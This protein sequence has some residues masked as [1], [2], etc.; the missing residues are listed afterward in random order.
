MDLA[1]R[2]DFLLRTQAVV[3]G[4]QKST[5]EDC[6]LV[7]IRLLDFEQL[8][9]SLGYK[10]LDELLTDISQKLRA[11]VAPGDMVS[12]WHGG[13]FSTLHSFRNKAETIHAQEIVRFVLGGLMQPFEVETMKLPVRACASY[14]LWSQSRPSSVDEFFQQLLATTRWLPLLEHGE[15]Y[16][17]CEMEVS[18]H[19]HPALLAAEL[20]NALRAGTQLKLFYQPIFSL[21]TGHLMGFE[22][23]MRW[24]HPEFGCIPPTEFI[25]VAESNKLIDDVTVFCLRAAFQQ[26]RQW[27]EELGKEPSLSINITGKQLASLKLLK[28]FFQLLREHSLSA[29]QFK[30]EVTESSL[31]RNIEAARKVVEQ[32][33]QR[34]CEISIDDF[35]TGYSSL[36]LLRNIPFNI[37]KIDKSFVSQITHDDRSAAIIRMIVDLVKA[38]HRTCIAEGVETQEQA[39]F[40]KAIGVDYGQGYHYGRPAPAEEAT[41]ILKQSELCFADSGK[42]G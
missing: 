13:R 27:K 24:E 40:L 8:I 16:P 36:S 39:Q 26:C 35:G 38:F 23:L 18:K 4:C 29:K 9:L 11:H 14:V 28:F 33:M 21:R 31:V 6:L 17:F 32:A 30:V 22:G 20:K 3:T 42:L 34:G 41:R 12:Y 5:L 37:L 25:P 19:Q 2:A 1:A 15:I 7:E 10:A